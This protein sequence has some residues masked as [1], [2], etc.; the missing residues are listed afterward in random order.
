MT[1]QGA[2]GILITPG[3]S[4]AIV[5]AIKKARDAGVLVIA[6]DT[7]TEPQEAA[8]ALF[9]TDN[10]KAGELIGQYA[11]AAAK[12]AGITPQIAMLDL[13]PGISVGRRH[14][15]FLKGFGIKEGDPQIVGAAPTFG[16]QAKGQAAMEKLLQKDPGINVI[17]TI[18]EPAAPRWRYP[19][20]R[21]PARNRRT[22]SS[23]PST[24]AA[25]H[26]ERHEGGHHRRHLAAVP[27]EDGG[28]GR[29]EGRGGCAR[30]REALGLHR[31]RLCY[32][33]RIEGS[34]P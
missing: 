14:D 3:D 27:A 4:K 32:E 19:R 18:N 7:P 5:P 12:E 26:Q 31:H 20:S 16:D 13:A 28:S 15:G 34:L 22:S 29:G 25:R 33:H 11:K 6:L 9:A 23:C 2:K 30:R 10:L 1:T 8:D 17:Y 21:R 24:A